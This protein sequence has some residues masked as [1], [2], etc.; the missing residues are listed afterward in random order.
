MLKRKK[1]GMEGMEGRKEG[2]KEGREGGRE[3]GLGILRW[4]NW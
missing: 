1:K 2:R 4:L 3:G